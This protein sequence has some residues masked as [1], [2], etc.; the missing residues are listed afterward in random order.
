MGGKRCKK[1]ECWY[2]GEAVKLVKRVLNDQ[3]VSCKE[4]RVSD[5]PTGAKRERLKRVEALKERDIMA[6]KLRE[7][8]RL[9]A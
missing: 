5:R 4:T 1:E 2:S 8:D 7:L 6:Q 9:V 3:G